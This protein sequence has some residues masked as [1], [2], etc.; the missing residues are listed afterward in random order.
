MTQPFST[1]IGIIGGG[2]LGK[3]LIE[4]ALPWNVEFNIL[5]ASTD[6]PSARYAST[7]IAGSLMDDQKIKELAA[8]SDVITY[9]IEHVNVNTLFELEAMGKTV[10]PS[11]T[12]LSIIQNK[13]KQ[14]QFY[15]NNKLATSHFVIT[16]SEEAQSADL[17]QFEGEKVVVKSCTGGYDGKGVSIQTKQEIRNGVVPN[18]FSGDV[19]LEEFVP[20]VTELSII[21][22]RTQSG[23]VTYFPAVEMMFDPQINL[24]DYLFAPSNV[25][26]TIQN[27]AQ[28]LSID[29]IEALNGIGLFAVELFVT[30]S[31][32]CLINEIAPRPHNSGHHTIEANY[33]SQYEQLMR[34]MLNLPLGNTDL[35]SP[36]V[37]TNIVGTEGVTGEYKLAGLEELSKTKGAYL[38]WYNKSVTKPGRKMGHFTVLDNDLSSA[39][40][41]SA[42]LKN[43]LRTVKPE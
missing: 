27:N 3:M 6:C 40:E 11:A 1:K 23:E 33:T 16:S 22:A 28:K 38:H 25:D 35:V 13:G 31:G 36:A 18:I 21:V 20:D 42:F 10:I 15:S 4:S 26:S 12:V 24:V 17:E 34:V 32:E 14:K 29:A 7:F 9:E 5:E 8:I 30:Q 39:I 43:K 41:K 2:Q 37:M 19:V